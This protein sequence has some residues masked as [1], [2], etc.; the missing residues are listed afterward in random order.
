MAVITESIVYMP[1]Y[2]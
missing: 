1:H 2:V